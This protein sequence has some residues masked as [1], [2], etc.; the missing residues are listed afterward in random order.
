MKKT[1]ITYDMYD[2]MMDNLVEQ[3]EF[4]KLYTK[5]KYIY[6]PPRGGLPMAVHLAHHLDLTL[7]D[8]FDFKNLPS[9]EW[10]KVLLVDDVADT[11][12]TLQAIKNSFGV[13]FTIATLHYKPRSIVK[14]QFYVEETTDWLIYP[15]ERLDETPNREGY[16]DEHSS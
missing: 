2:H 1:I 12:K 4:S 7:L 16:N 10:E 6:G 9:R 5:V 3:I 13:Y 11:G 14:P 15:W 8:R